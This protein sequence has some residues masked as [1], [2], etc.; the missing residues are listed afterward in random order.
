MMSAQNK[1]EPA[2]LEVGSPPLADFGLGLACVLGGLGLFFGSRDFQP[3]IPDT[4]I[5][6]GLLPSICAFVLAFFG[7]AL[8][9]TSMRNW[10]AGAQT[11]DNEEDGGGSAFFTMILLG[12]LVLVILLIPYFGFIITTSL[13]GFA[14][15]WAGR[16]KWW[17]AALSSVALTLVVDYL[18]AHVMRVPLPTGI[19]F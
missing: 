1:N 4:L 18:F 11:V 14:V 19:L 10:R 2:S 16:A 5:G 15:T 3:M 9:I 17:G 6:P 7:A 13:Y 12:G 8:C